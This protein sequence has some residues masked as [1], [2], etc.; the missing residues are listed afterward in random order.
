MPRTRVYMGSVLLLAALES[1]QSGCP[2]FDKMI[3]AGRTIIRVIHTKEGK[4]IY[5]MDLSPPSGSASTFT[6]S[7][8]PDEAGEAGHYWARVRYDTLYFDDESQSSR[9]LFLW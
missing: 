7:R 2:M 8:S 6:T 5:D 9:G 4:E 1:L 3:E